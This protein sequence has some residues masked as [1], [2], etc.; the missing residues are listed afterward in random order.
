[1]SEQPTQPN[2]IRVYVEK[3]NLHKSD[4]ARFKYKGIL[5]LISHFNDPDL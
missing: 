3:S 4:K 2:G 1:M 5:H